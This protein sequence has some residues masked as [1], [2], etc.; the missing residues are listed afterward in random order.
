MPRSLPCTQGVYETTTRSST[1]YWR[2]KLAPM[3][4]CFHVCLE[5]LVALGV[6]P[7]VPEENMSEN[8]S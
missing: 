2:I 4:I 8:V 1:V 5:V 3:L 6:P 7:D